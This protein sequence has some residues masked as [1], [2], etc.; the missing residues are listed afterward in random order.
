[1]TYARRLKGAEKKG[2]K[3]KGAQKKRGE[4]K[5]EGKNSG[6]K[7]KQLQAAGVRLQA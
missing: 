4:K 1:M 6:E 3:K 2:E 5:R 7:Y